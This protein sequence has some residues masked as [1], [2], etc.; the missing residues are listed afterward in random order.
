M[1]RGIS[2][3]LSPVRVGAQV[4]RRDLDVAVAGP[5][6]HDVNEVLNVGLG[7]ELVELAG[8]DEREDVCRGGGVIVAAEH[9]PKF[10]RGGDRREHS[11]A[12]I[13]L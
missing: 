2:A 11:L 13:V 6:R 10:A 1:G 12:D 9:D 4:L 5:L 7:V 3:T 8:R